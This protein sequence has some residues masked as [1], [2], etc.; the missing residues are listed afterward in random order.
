MLKPRANC[1]AWAVVFYSS[2]IAA[3][4]FRVE[5]FCPRQ[6][7]YWQGAKNGA[8]FRVLAA[9]VGFA[10]ALRPPAGNA[11]VLDARGVQVYF[12]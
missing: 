2:Y 7:P 11:R 4:P 5:Y 1:E 9:A 12:V 8:G 10:L 3:P 6:A